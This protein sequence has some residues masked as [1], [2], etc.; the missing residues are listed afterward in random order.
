MVKRRVL[1]ALAVSTLAIG[2][3][4]STGIVGPA[5]ASFPEGQGV[6]SDT[7][8]VAAADLLE[9]QPSLV[10][11]GAQY[12]T[13]GTGLRNQARGGITIN[14]VTGSPIAAFAY[15]AV[16]TAGP[17]VSPLDQLEVQRQSPGSAN[18]TVFGTVVG[19]GGSPCWPGDTLTVF[20]AP[21]SLKVASGSGFYR[22]GQVPKTPVSSNAGEDPW[23]AGLPA[24]LYEGASLVIVYEGRGTTSIY[25]VGM[26]GTLF[27]GGPGISYTL[28][29]P[30]VAL[31]GLTT[32]DTIGADG[33][34][35]Y[36]RSAFAGL[37]DEATTINGVL[38]SGP[39][40]PYNDSDWNGIDSL[41][42]PSLWD[43]AGHDIS[44]AVPAGTAS[45]A[46]TTGSSSSGGDCLNLGA[47]LVNTQ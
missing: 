23:E 31:G 38:V 17:A 12:E 47:N 14:G 24:P 40:S 36:S 6:T 1:S 9:I 5:S 46:V 26:A 25:D 7:S 35:G 37:A 27:F 43:T 3:W 28:V 39:G 21:V 15:W 45:L 20:R 16:I 2:T 33:Q 11:E 22:V 32:W 8:R 42:V 41:P 30:G 34:H 18:V 29:L 10:F 4:V 19:T 44:A 13:G